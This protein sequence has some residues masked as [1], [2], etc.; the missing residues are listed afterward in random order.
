MAWEEDESATYIVVVNHEEQYSIWLVLFQALPVKACAEV[1]VT[2]EPNAV[3][4]E[5]REASVEELFAALSKTCDVHYRVS[6][7]LKRPISG[8]FAGSLLQVL[9]RVLQGYDFSIE[10]STNGVSITVYGSSSSPDKHFDLAKGISGP[11]SPSP[12]QPMLSAKH[13]PGHGE[14]IRVHGMTATARMHRLPTPE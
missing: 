13:G 3:K 5:A 9:V 8:S 4:I 6:T 10:T 1:S 12:P 7:G 2:G 14:L 11:S